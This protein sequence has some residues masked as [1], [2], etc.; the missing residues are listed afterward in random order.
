MKIEVIIPE[1]I[2][3]MIIEKI[4]SSGY[5]VTNSE[6]TIKSVIDNW[7]DVSFN[8]SDQLELNLEVDIFEAGHIDELVKQGFVEMVSE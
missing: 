1:E 2:Q 6:M 8:V 3:K 7:I 5:K 4:N